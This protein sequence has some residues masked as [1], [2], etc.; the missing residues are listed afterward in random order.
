M[1]SMAQPWQRCLLVVRPPPPV[2]LLLLNRVATNRLPLP[3]NQAVATTAAALPV[4]LLGRPDMRLAE[5]C[6]GR[7]WVPNDENT[8]V[9]KRSAGDRQLHPILR[10][11][12]HAARIRQSCHVSGDLVCGNCAQLAGVRHLRPHPAAHSYPR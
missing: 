11:R 9:A 5:P 2:Q 8:T 7:G 12:R 1:E 10:T 6:A 3:P 4:L